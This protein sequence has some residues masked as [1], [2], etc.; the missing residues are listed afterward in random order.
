MEVSEAE[1]PEVPAASGPRDTSFE[2]IS[3]LFHLPINE[4]SKRLGICVT[5]LKKLCRRHGL[6]RWPYRKLKSLERINVT[7]TARSSVRPNPH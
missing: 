6:S 5:L 2:S 1:P 3:S 4:A 7:T